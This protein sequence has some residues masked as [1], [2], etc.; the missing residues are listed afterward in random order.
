MCYRT[1]IR[2]PSALEQRYN[3]E[4]VL[5]PVHRFFVPPRQVQE[6]RVCI[7]G[8]DVW[9]ITKVLRLSRGAEIIVF[10]GAGREYRVKLDDVKRREI[11]GVVQEQWQRQAESPLWLMLAQGVPRAAKMDLIVQKA[12]E[13]GVNKIVPLCTERAD[14]GNRE[15]ARS[16]EKSAQKLD[17]WSRIGMEAAKQCQRSALPTLEPFLT[18]DEFLAQA[19][20]AD[21]RLM[22]WE[23][24]QQQRLTTVLRQQPASVT[25]AILVIGPEGGLTDGEAERLTAAGYASVSLGPR[26]LRTETAGL[27]ALSILQYEFGD[28]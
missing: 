13:I 3:D 24:E 20:A 2:R 12:T 27:V 10:D 6:G 23:G 14:P 16:P 9:H 25:S 11:T 26:I 8:A 4:V 22:L 28:Y 15:T 1:W 19:F 21:L 18:L 5:M 7:R 17:R